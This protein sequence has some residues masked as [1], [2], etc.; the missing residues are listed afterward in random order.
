MSEQAKSTSTE[1]I[2]LPE[3]KISLT[4]DELIIISKAVYQF[5]HMKW[6]PPTN[7]QIAYMLNDNDLNRITR[8]Q[9]ILSKIMERISI[10]DQLN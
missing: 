9:N 7:A 5:R 8:L 2:R 10:D 6:G 4:F 3:E 1:I